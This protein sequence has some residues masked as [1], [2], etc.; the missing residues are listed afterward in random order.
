VFAVGQ[1]E[2]RPST[3][4]FRSKDEV[5]ELVP[6]SEGRDVILGKIRE[7][8]LKEIGPSRPYERQRHA[9]MLVFFSGFCALP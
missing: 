2:R 7:D 8:V 3:S 6:E 5:Y 1:I 9:L 4:T